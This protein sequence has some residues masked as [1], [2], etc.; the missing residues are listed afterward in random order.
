MTSVRQLAPVFERHLPNGKHQQDGLV[1]TSALSPGTT[2][3]IGEPGLRG[4]LTV[5]NIG[6]CRRG[7]M[8]Y[9]GARSEHGAPGVGGCTQEED[10][11]EKMKRAMLA[12]AAAQTFAGSSITAA[13]SPGNSFQTQR[14]CTST[15]TSLSPVMMAFIGTLNS[16]P[17]S[18]LS[19]RRMLSRYPVYL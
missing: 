12:S 9:E 15:S 3:T 7:G 8:I 6:G 16:N 11:L 1:S 17:H 14:S 18:H 4:Q 2:A 5:P 19:N 10:S 13:Q